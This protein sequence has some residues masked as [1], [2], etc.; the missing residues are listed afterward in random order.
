MGFSGRAG[1]ALPKAASH[2]RE[3]F[4]TPHDPWQRR[5]P[6]NAERPGGGH[7]IRVVGGYLEGNLEV[8]KQIQRAL[9]SLS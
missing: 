9:V 2:V 1:E 4:G 5:K 6:S 3:A 7:P 8:R